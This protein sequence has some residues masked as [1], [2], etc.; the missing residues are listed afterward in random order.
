[1][2]LYSC[3]KWSPDEGIMLWVGDRSGSRGHHSSVEGARIGAVRGSD[4]I[5]ADDRLRTIK[6]PLYSFSFRPP[7]L[8]RSKDWKCSSSD[9]WYG[10]R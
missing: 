10:G 8:S 9:F 3:S 4:H 7:I 5:V 1:M 2:L 6:V